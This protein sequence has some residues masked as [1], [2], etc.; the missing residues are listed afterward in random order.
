VGCSY[1]GTNAPDC[2][3]LG[4]DP[5]CDCSA[6]DEATCRA[7]GDR[8]TVGE[9]PDCN[10]GSSYVGC[11]DPTETFGCPA[12]ACEPGCRTG[13]DCQDQGAY[14]APPGSPTPCG[15]C[16]MPDQQCSSDDECQAA[17]PTTICDVNT[18]GCGCVPECLPGCQGDGQCA[19][20][21]ICLD[22]RCQPAPC[23]S[24]TACPPNFACGASGGA[25]RSCQRRPCS[26]DLDCDAP[27]GY[28]VEGLCY[29]ELGDCQLPVP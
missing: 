28:C 3:A 5:Q 24:N 14:C 12:I 16:N 21:Q 9:C 29:A 17:N 8:C 25:G 18:A 11:F 27:A 10:G 20:G 22:A 1:A 15:I 2:P 19:A 26:T 13:A 4:C 7:V 6:F 23:D